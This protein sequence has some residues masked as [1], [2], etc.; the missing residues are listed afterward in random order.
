MNI[1]KTLLPT[2]LLILLLSSCLP[3]PD[4]IPDPEPWE[5]DENDVITTETGLSYVIHEEGSGDK[6]SQGYNVSV[7]YSGFLEDGRLFDTSRTTNQPL[8]FIVGIG[9]VI[10]GF[11]QGV[12]DMRIGERRTLIIPDSLGYGAAGRP[13]QIPPN[14][15]LIFDLELMGKA[16]N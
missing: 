10:S 12:L 13:P 2:I 6:P 15:T 5:Y 4:I 1:F 11:D 3:E 14:S 16:P 8:L 7:H 9:Q